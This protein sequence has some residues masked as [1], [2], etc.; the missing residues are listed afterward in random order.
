MRMLREC[1]LYQLTF[2][3][4]ESLSV[5]CYLVVE[6]DDLTLIDTGIPESFQGIMQAAT[7]INKPIARIVLTHAH[8]DHIGGLDMI[9]Q[10]LPHTQV[11]I[12]NRE[13]RLLT[14]DLTLNANEPQTPIRGTIP[15]NVNTKADILLQEGDRIKSLVALATPGH[16]PGSMSFFDTRSKALIA[17]D[18][19]QTEGGIAVAGLFCPSFPYPSLGTWNKEVALESARKLHEYSPSLLA[20]GHGPMIKEP[21]SDM[22]HAI[23]E[24]EQYE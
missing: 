10:A 18:A 23:D 7:K 17:G 5:N 1:S 11:Y 15:K 12:S 8:H 2:F 20:V 14:G 24:A 19:F 4:G 6:D 16:T 13:Y 9:K 22:K 3:K 21:S